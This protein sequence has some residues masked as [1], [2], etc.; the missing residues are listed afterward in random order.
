M[1]LVQQASCKL[2][3]MATTS[4]ANAKLAVGDEVV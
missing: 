2:A 4:Y 1:L 3:V